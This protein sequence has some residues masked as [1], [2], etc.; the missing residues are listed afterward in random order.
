V[1]IAEQGGAPIQQVH[2]LISDVRFSG[3]CH[4]D[5]HAMNGDWPLAT[6]LPLVGGHEGAGVVV[7]RG[8]L[9]KD[10]DIGD[11]V[12]IKVWK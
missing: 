2:L 12:G 3:V 6:K 5:L 11:H 7:A 9:V 8:T 10:V 1:S 4:T